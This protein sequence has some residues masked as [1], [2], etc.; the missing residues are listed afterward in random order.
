VHFSFFLGFFFTCRP[1]LPRVLFS[2]SFPGDF[3]WLHAVFILLGIPAFAALQH[4]GGAMVRRARRLPL[5]PTAVASFLSVPATAMLVYFTMR[6]FDASVGWNHA[7][8]HNSA[9]PPVSGARGA[10][11]TF[12]FGCLYVVVFAWLMITLSRTTGLAL[13]NPAAVRDPGL[14]IDFNEDYQLL[15][16]EYLQRTEMNVHP[17]RARGLSLVDIAARR[18]HIHRAHALGH[19]G[20]GHHRGASISVT[21][22]ASPH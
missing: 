19:Y 21:E 20:A 16:I 14:P 2:C 8:T 1:L 10:V 11:Y 12:A 4:L 5:W 3:F 22:P 6:A 15:L 13:A 7:L 17:E 9:S 18:R